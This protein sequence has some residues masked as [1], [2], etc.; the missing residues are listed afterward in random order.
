MSKNIGLTSSKLAYK[1]T[2]IDIV[3]PHQN[4]SLKIKNLKNKLPFYLTY[5]QH[6]LNELNI[7]IKMLYKSIL[8]LHCI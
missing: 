5:Y 2:E 8:R 3:K 6:R 7:F 4:L 1:N